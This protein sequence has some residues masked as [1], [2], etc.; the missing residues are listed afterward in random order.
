MILFIRLVLSP[1][2]NTDIHLGIPI[3]FPFDIRDPMLVVVIMLSLTVNAFEFVGMVT[4][5]GR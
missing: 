5:H 1:Y 3:Y 4:Y 2:S